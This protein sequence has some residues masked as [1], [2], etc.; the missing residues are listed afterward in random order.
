MGDNCPWSQLVYQ[1]SAVHT[2]GDLFRAAVSA[3]RSRVSR[4]DRV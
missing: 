2:T 3:P 1:P 4:A